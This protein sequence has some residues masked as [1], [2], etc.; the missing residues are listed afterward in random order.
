MIITPIQIRFNDI[1]GFG[2][3]NNSV[4]WSYFDLGR[5]DCINQLLGK[6]FFS[7]N[8][9]LVLVHVEGDY[10]I[11]TLLHDTIVVQTCITRV[12]NKSIQ[13]QQNIVHTVTGN[14]HV[15]SS[16]IVSGLNKMAQKSIFIKDE[17]RA[18]IK[19]AFPNI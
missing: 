14:V 12:G 2:H 10:K 18:N 7:K 16:S 4:Y 17:W 5:V 6:D 8:E 19:Q 9:T 11:Q 1:D 15:I 13:M 3:V